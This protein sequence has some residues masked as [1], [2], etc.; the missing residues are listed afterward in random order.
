VTRPVRTCAG[1]GGKAP[2]AELIRFVAREG[3]LTAAAKAPGRGVYTHRRL[4][5]F[6]R[7]QATR[8]FNRTLK[9]SVRV[10]PALARIYT[11]ANG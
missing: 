9:T 4:A 1:C 7:A 10:D 11:D 6:E 8:A 5:C 2:Q 3:V